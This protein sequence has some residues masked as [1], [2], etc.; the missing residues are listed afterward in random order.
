M[1]CIVHRITKSRTR[2]SDFHSL[3]HS[4]SNQAQHNTYS[5]NKI[6]EILGEYDLFWFKEP[7][8]KNLIKIMAFLIQKMH[9]H[10]QISLKFP[11]L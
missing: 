5:G 9:I 1:D 6:E 2:L 7:F 10:C 11:T 4:L 3:T 8:E